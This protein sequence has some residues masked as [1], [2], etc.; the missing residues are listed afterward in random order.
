VGFLLYREALTPNKI[1][2]ILIVLVGL[3]FINKS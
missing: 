2:G 1:I 3:Y